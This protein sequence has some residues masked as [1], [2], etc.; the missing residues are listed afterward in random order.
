MVARIHNC[1]FWSSIAL[2]TGQ[3]LMR[4]C[5]INRWLDGISTTPGVVRQFVAVPLRQGLTVKAQLTGQEARGGMQF[6]VFPLYSTTVS[7]KY[8]MKLLNLYKTP[9]Q[10][11][12]SLGTV[13]CMENRLLD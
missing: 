5:F 2:D 13:I 4:L 12:L 11:G 3:M 6:D 1:M 9:R 7:F 10:L 8:G